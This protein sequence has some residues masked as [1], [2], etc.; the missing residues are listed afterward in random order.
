MRRIGVRWAVLAVIALLP[1]SI[2][3]GACAKDK[4]ADERAAEQV[5]KG[6][7]AHVE[8]DLEAAAKAYEEALELDE[9]NKLAT[10]NLG[11]VRQTQGDN[12]AA[13]RYYRMTIA[14]DPK[15]AP[16]LF[17]LAIVVTPT[18]PAEAE[19][20]Y[21]RAIEADPSQ[22]GPHRNLGFLLQA[23]GRE[24][25]AQREFA[26]AD[27][28]DPQPGPTTSSPAAEPAEPTSTTARR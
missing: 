23:Q 2:V 27:Q 6:L 20:L 15:Y 3:G 19:A 13:E 4:P 11:L 22:A 8:G 14:V 16:A 26:I 1:M 28:L 21:R 25:E 9:N 5:D 24:E 17:N 7:A 12:A 18:N 10:Y